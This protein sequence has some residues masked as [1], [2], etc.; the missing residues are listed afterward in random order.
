MNSNVNLVPAK[1]VRM[2][3]RYVASRGA[4]I[5]PLLDAHGIT[6]VIL[7]NPHAEIEIKLFARLMEE[8]AQTIGAP[9]LGLEWAKAYPLSAT[10]I[11][12]YIIMHSRNVRE[13]LVNSARY[14]NLVMSPVD[15]ITSFDVHDGRE[16]GQYSWRWP[17]FLDGAG[18]QYKCFM[19]ALMVMR[20]RTGTSRPWSPLA[21]ELQCKDVACPRLILEIYGA[22]TAFN[23]Y[24]NSILVDQ[25]DLSVE[26]AVADRRLFQIIRGQAERLL[27][28]LPQRDTLVQN[29]RATIL[30]SLGKVEI[31]LETIAE[32]LEIQPRTLKSMLAREGGT[33][34][35]AV[36]NDAKRDLARHY[37]SETDLQLTE[38]ALILGYSELSVFTRAS[39]RW[40]G[41]PPRALR[42]KLRC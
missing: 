13:A 35:Q 23:A 16:I 24:R 18:V 42:Q 11:L 41:A 8:V 14:A 1:F 39:Q 3:S 4:D 33:T 31:S 2:F 28:E 12:G 9:C 17:S 19:S 10:G 25:D 37:L 36:L 20:L 7:D 34:F 40:F 29:V 21:I 26:F 22:D 38:I 6:A 32:K 15:P 5:A 30:E 27:A